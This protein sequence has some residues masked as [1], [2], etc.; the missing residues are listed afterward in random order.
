MADRVSNR[1]S[2]RS[3]PMGSMSAW[4]PS[5]RST[6]HHRGA[7]VS[8]WAGQVRSARASGAVGA[9]FSNGILA[10]GSGGRVIEGRPFCCDALFFGPIWE[11]VTVNRGGWSVRDYVP[12]YEKTSWPRGRRRS[13][14]APVGARLGEKEEVVLFAHLLPCSR[15]CEVLSRADVPAQV[16][17][18]VPALF[19]AR[20]A[21]TS[22]CRVK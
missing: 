17:A 19:S 3:G 6:L 2:L 22:A 20:P 21:L 16:G 13:W 4:L 12:S 8:C 5:R 9:Y 15:N 1:A 18:A 11:P 14:R 10:M 7:L